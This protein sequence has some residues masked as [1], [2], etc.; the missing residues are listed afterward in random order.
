MALLSIRVMTICNNMTE[1]K[2]IRVP[3]FLDDPLIGR[4]ITPLPLGI[5]HGYIIIDN[6]ML[7]YKESKSSKLQKSFSLKNLQKLLVRK[8]NVSCWTKDHRWDPY[9]RI[10]TDIELYLVDTDGE[11]HELLPKFS[12]NVA[13]WGQKEW[14]RFLSELC[15]FSGLP[16]EEV[17]EP[18]KNV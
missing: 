4:C 13:G 14:D 3:F 16:L 12:M 9:G 1:T 8:R 17:N 11:K 6:E 18:A 15:E 2:K 5:F 10:G 7:L